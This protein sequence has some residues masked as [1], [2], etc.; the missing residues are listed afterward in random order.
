MFEDSLFESSETLSKRNPWTAALSFA[1]QGVLAGGLVL[2]PIIY[3]GALP[4]RQLTSFLTEPAPPP[5][6]A[7]VS[8]HAR[9]AQP[10]R[11][12]ADTVLEVPRSIP[13]QIAI[14]HDQSANEDRSGAPD[15]SGV[16]G[17]TGTG[18]PNSVISNVIQ[19]PLAMPK[20]VS[21]SK[22]RVSSGVAQGLLIHQTKPVYPAL[23][24]QARIQGT[25]LLQAVVGKDGTVQDLRVVS[26]HPLL[27]KAAL[28]AVKLWRYKPYRLNDQPVEVDTEIIVNFTLSNR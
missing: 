16:P 15:W 27:V 3:T 9:G 7:P 8:N 19:V 5:G 23:A 21:P 12:L 4:G 26:G 22:V 13:R 11:V 24:M 14:L 18:V 10:R 17:G 25:V 1:M 28:E 2:L 20:V 6:P